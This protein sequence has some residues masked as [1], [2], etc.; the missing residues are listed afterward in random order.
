[1]AQEAYR[2]APKRPPRALPRRPQEAKI[3]DFLLVFGELWG[4]PLFGF[5]TIQDGGLLGVQSRLEGSEIAP[6]LSER[7]SR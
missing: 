4:S 2:T 5:P 3:I 6:Q 7:A 1:M